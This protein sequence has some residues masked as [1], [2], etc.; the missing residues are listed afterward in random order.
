LVG[1]VPGSK[2][3]SDEKNIIT[4]KVLPKLT[5]DHKPIQLLLEDEEDLGPIPFCFTPLWIEKVG[6]MET[7][8]AA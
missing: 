2:R 4:T 1:Q 8:K 7:V 6:F 5:S 3:P